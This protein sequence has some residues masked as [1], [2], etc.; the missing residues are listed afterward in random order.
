MRGSQNQLP[1]G[2]VFAD[3]VLMIEP[4]VEPDGRIERAVLVHAEPGQFFVENFAIFL[5]EIAVLD[6]PIGDGAADAMDQL[7]N[8][9]FALGGVLLAVKIFR[10]DHFCGEDRPG[11]RHF[12]VVLLEN[13]FAAVVGDFG[14]AFIPFDLVEGLDLRVAEDAIHFEGLGWLLRSPGK[15][16]HELHLLDRLFG[17]LGGALRRL[18]RPAGAETSSSRASIIGGS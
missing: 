5:G 14:G 7:A 11:F 10:D 3:A 12:D 1:F 4:D 13:D 9:R 18:C 15:L 2:G 17:R 6:A 16:Y 8:G